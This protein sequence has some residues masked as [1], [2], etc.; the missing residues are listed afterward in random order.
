MRSS[1]AM[2]R[3][4]RRAQ[5]ALLACLAAAIVT[6]AAAAA[7]PTHRA[8]TTAPARPAAARQTGI[9]TSSGH[10]KL[11]ARISAGIR[12]ALAGRSSVVSLAVAD[13]PAGVSCQLHQSRHFH[14][15]SIVKAI[16]LGALLHELGTEH[17]DLTAEQVTLTTE[18]I[19]ES[20]N[21]AATTL[22]NEVGPA[23]LQRFL[24][25]AKMT[26]TNLGQHGYWGLTEVSAHDELL[27][28]QLFLTRNQV[29]DNPSR[30][31]ALDLMADV[32]PSQ[33]WGVPA[34]APADVTV[35]LKNGWLPDPKLWVINS[36]GDFTGRDCDYSVA[37]LTRGNPSMAY[38]V[39][40]VERAAKVINR[41]LGK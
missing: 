2:H 27:L 26:E 19:T 33:R 20:D 31:Y 17:R 40:T 39:T 11:A 10:P 16:I 23:S 1:R 9:C 29:L 35:H 18:M 5:P 7:W 12:K 15:A 21:A 6:V 13:I 36:I 37:I 25:L 24:S 38:G 28:L 34:G 41:D 4:R 14:S 30:D 3:R 32:V 22:W 8:A